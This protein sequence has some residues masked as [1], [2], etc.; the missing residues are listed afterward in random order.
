M[1]QDSEDVNDFEISREKVS[2]RKAADTQFIVI[3]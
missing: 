1:N 2:I 3:I